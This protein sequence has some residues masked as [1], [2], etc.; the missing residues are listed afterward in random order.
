MKA[1]MIGE[2]GPRA[3]SRAHSKQTLTILFPRQV[4]P[5]SARSRTA[6]RV[7]IKLSP[8]LSRENNYYTYFFKPAV[9]Q[10]PDE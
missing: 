5:P 7:V 4:A 10:C 6:R 3:P 8:E 2:M 9:L 1:A